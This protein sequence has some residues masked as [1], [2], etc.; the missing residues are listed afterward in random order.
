MSDALTMGTLRQALRQAA[1]DHN[2]P[3]VV[4]VDRQIAELLTAIRGKTLNAEERQ[5][6]QA[7]RDIHRQV[8]E[9]CQGQSGIIAD[10]MALTMRN[11]EGAAAYAAFMDEG[12]L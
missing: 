1:A 12:D 9:Y 3:A 5:A 11:R 10:K 6:L 2:W 4:N 8:F 7:L